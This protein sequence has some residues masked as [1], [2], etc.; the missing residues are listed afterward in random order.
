M[1]L[2]H[3]VEGDHGLPKGPR[4]AAHARGPG[5]APCRRHPPHTTAPQQHQA[6]K[7]TGAA[8]DPVRA[9]GRGPVTPE[10][11][12]NTVSTHLAGRDA[13]QRR[14]WLP[15]WCGVL[16][17][18]LACVWSLSWQTAVCLVLLQFPPA[19]ALTRL[20]WG[21]SFGTCRVAVSSTGCVE[22]TGLDGGQDILQGQWV[23]G[24]SLP[25]PEPPVLGWAAVPSQRDTLLLLLEFGTHFALHI[26]TG[27]SPPQPIPSAL[28]LVHTHIG[29]HRQHDVQQGSGRGQQEA[30]GGCARIDR[31]R[32]GCGV[33][34][35][36]PRRPPGGPQGMQG[37]LLRHTVRGTVPAHAASASRGRGDG[38]APRAVGG[39]VGPTS[40]PWWWPTAKG[41][42][43]LL[44]P[45]TRLPCF[46]VC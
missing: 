12:G 25:A 2:D 33:P 11:P 14:P 31:G 27:H 16:S 29:A 39:E 36:R 10:R 42:A 21:G 32:E 17:P 5:W 26:G 15:G 13:I 23:G 20:C 19:A 43:L 1:Q 37:T 44:R 45:H 41:A 34:D 7:K 35:P 9:L 8:I 4:P 46:C 3:T 40:P 24:G 18:S 28:T 38:R 22:G 30:R 6:A